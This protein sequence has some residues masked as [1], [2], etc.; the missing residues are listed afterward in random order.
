MGSLDLCNRLEP[1]IA[2]RPDHRQAGVHH[3]LC[4][5]LLS[6]LLTFSLGRLHPNELDFEISAKRR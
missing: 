1:R 6:D 2:R 3:W 5:M 4:V